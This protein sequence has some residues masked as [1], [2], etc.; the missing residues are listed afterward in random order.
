MKVLF[1]PERQINWLQLLSACPPTG[2]FGVLKKSRLPRCRSRSN[3]LPSKHPEII[4]SK[5]FLRIP[6]LCEQVP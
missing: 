6:I 2:G 5:D 3:Y 4:F 1:K